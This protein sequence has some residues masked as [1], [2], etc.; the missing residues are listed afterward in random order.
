MLMIF[1]KSKDIEL[2]WAFKWKRIICKK[3][4]FCYFVLHSER[5]IEL[6]FTIH[7]SFQTYSSASKQRCRGPR[8]KWKNNAVNSSPC[9]TGSQMEWTREANLF[10]SDQFLVFCTSSSI[11]AWPNICFF[12]SISLF[13]NSH[14]SFIY[15]LFVHKCVLTSLWRPVGWE[16][17]VW[18]HCSQTYRK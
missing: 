13:N 18:E 17:S 4:W 3:K 1:I 14:P 8:N 2:C 16:V 11:Q 5:S 9:L 7:S 10:C 6:S 15:F 12:S